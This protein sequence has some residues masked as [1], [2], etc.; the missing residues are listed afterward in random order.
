[1]PFLLRMLKV[2]LKCIIETFRCVL[3][4]SQRRDV[5]PEG[6]MGTTGSTQRWLGPGL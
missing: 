4:A 3:E 5:P 1:M 2:E 6:A